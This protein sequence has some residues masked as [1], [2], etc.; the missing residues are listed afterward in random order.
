MLGTLFIAVV[1]LVIGALTGW[2]IPLA[3]KSQRPHGLVGDILAGVLSMLVA[4]LAEW[5]FILP[6]LNFR[7][8]LAIAAAIGDPFGLALIVLWL[9]RRIKS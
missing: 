2:G 5:I 9:M 3:V 4:G 7:G 6:A 8:W 1:L